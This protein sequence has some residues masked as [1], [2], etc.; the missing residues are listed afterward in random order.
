MAFLP[1]GGIKRPKRYKNI[2]PTGGFILF[3]RIILQIF[4]DFVLLFTLKIAV[5]IMYQYYT[6]TY[7]LRPPPCGITHRLDGTYPRKPIL[8]FARTIEPQ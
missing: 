4:I 1:Q 3:E 2:R 6:C 8:M 5:F 7:I